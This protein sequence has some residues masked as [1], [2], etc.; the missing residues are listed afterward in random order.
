MLTRKY[1][2]FVLVVSLLGLIQACKLPALLQC[3][4]AL[5][6]PAQYRSEKDTTNVAKIQWKQFFK[7]QNLIALIDTALKNNQ[8]LNIIRQE[9]EIAQNEVRL[10]RGAY[11]P[12][13]TIGGV[14]GVEKTPRYTRFGAVDA[15][16]DITEGKKIPEVLPN[17]MLSANVSWEVDIWKRLRKAKKSAVL[18]YLATIEGRNLAQTKLISEMAHVYY[19]LLALDNYLEILQ[20]NIEIQ[21]NALKIINLEKNAG[22]V[23][24]LAVRR[25][26]AEVS[27]NQSLKYEIQQQIVQMENYLNFLAGRFPQPIKRNAKQFFNLPTDS[28]AVGIPSQLLDNR[29]DI[30]QATLNV[31]ATKLDVQVARARF[32]PAL[33]LTADMGI[34]AFNPKYLVTSLESAFINV[35]GGLVAPLV[36][37][38]AIKAEYYTASAKQIQALLQYEQTLLNA[39]VEVQNQLHNFK[40]LAQ[41]YTWKYKQVEA[42]NRSVNIVVNLFK[43]ARADY[44]EILLTQRDALEAKMELVEIKKRQMNAFVKMY[45]VLGGGWQ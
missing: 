6:M 21:Q 16:T 43:S 26:E 14:V 28:L 17:F 34:A 37:K 33:T 2:N 1:I 41:S 13:A 27:K 30:R 25:F 19:E 35:V 45:E 44:V 8:E 38:S 20:Q 9:I 31:E 18:R 10:R 40:N 7:D 12:F 15:S 32:L 11:L 39:F 29:P 4:S 22:Q 24:E 23:T 36:N 42:M 3:N 5:Q